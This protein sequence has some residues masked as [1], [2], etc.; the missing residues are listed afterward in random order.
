MKNKKFKNYQIGKE[1]NA[2]F[3]SYKDCFLIG[4]VCKFGATTMENSMMVP[5]KTKNKSCHMIQ[6]SQSWAYTQTK[7]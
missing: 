1:L 5:Q 6:Q 2:T 4:W 3:R 7:L